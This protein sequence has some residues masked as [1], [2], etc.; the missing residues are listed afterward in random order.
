MPELD[1]LWRFASGPKPTLFHGSASSRLD[2]LGEDEPAE[3]DT[4]A[5]AKRSSR[6][7]RGLMSY[8]ASL[9]G[10]LL[11]NIVLSMRGVHLSF[12]EAQPQ[13]PQQQSPAAAAAAAPGALGRSV[14]PDPLLGTPT[15]LAFV[16]V[17]SPGLA[18]P[19]APRAQTTTFGLRLELLQTRAA[20]K[21][22]S[23]GAG[24]VSQGLEIKGVAFYWDVGDPIPSRSDLAVEANR[25]RS[26][27]RAVSAQPSGL[28]TP[29]LGAKPASGPIAV[30]P[31]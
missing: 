29:S 28:N 12:R 11:R 7:Y 30:Q 23:P 13:Q 3:G 18:M 2:S 21:D 17:G 22:F 26:L 15:P 1:E 10:V 31:A 6:L 8:A 19:Q 4:A 14:T 5:P 27:S 20:K 24:W 16:G 25:V 9:L